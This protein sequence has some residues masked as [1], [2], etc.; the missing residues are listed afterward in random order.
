MTAYLYQHFIELIAL[1]VAIF[2]YLAARAAKYYTEKA[3]SLS[4]FDKRY[5]LYYDFKI[6]VNKLTIDDTKLLSECLSQAK[7]LLWEAQ[8]IFGEDVCGLLCQFKEHIAGTISYYR[9][10]NDMANGGQSEDYEV[11]SK[12][13]VHYD[14]LLLLLGVLLGE[15]ELSNL[16]FYFHK[17]L[18]D[19]EFRK[20]LS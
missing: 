1:I 2:A 17:Y 12:Y 11:I 20:S 14:L 8:Y 16:N 6:L 13:K 5:K 3:F 15:N 18:A 4:L 10:S 19:K 9:I 7:F